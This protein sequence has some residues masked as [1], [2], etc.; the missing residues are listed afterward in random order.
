MTTCS[1]RGSSANRIAAV[2]IA[3]SASNSV[4]GHVTMPSASVAI[5]AG[6]NWASSSSAMPSPVLYPSNSRLRND[7]M[8]WSNA[9]AT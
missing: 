4:I 8:T 2:A 1:T 3:S 5:S 7:S 9:T 6:S